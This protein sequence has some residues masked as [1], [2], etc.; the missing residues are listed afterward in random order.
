MVHELPE[1]WR[2]PSILGAIIQLSQ[3]GSLLFLLFK[4]FFPK[5]VSI[6]A[7]I[8]ALFFIGSL[9]CFLLIFLWN[10]T[11]QI[12]S[13]ERSLGLYMLTFTLGLLG[14]KKKEKTSVSF[15]NNFITIIDGTSTVTFLPYIGNY[16]KKEYIIPNYVG[17]SLSSMIPS[18]LGIIQG[19]GSGESECNDFLNLNN[20]YGLLNET[21]LLLPRIALKPAFKVST[22]FLIMFLILILSTVSF[23]LLHYAPVSI[24]SRNS[25]A[26]IDI[27]KP[28]SPI[29]Y[30]RVSYTSLSS[31]MEQKT[32]QIEIVKGSD[33]IIE[34]SKPGTKERA[35]LLTTSML[36]SF[37]NYGILPAFQSYSTL[38]YGKNAFHLSINLS[39]YFLRAPKYPKCYSAYILFGS[40]FF[41]F[42]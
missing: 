28:A 25:Y 8:Y 1:G 26:E 31:L 34:R 4:Y 13:E 22:F 18:I 7:I 2:L 10:K 21:N 40:K 16:F 38:P 3:I 24:R 42:F 33:D 32:G 27:D 6:V 29:D 5:H 23:S 35:I 11:V 20:S 37:V 12:G 9:S 41:I 19:S 36:V 39:K 17:E 15:I 30:N 14:K